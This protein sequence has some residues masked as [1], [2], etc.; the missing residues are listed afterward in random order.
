[1]G[2][3]GTNLEGF[4]AFE[5]GVNADKGAP[6]VSTNSDGA[7]ALL[8]GPA[9]L[10][11]IQA[12]VANGDFAIPPDAA[13]DTITEQNPLPYWTFTDVN[14]AGAITA[15][16]IVTAAAGSGNVLR[17]T[18]A[19]GTLTGKSAT[20]TR[21]VPVASSASRSFSYYTE[22]TFV[23]GTNSAQAEVTVSC[24]YY[25]Q[26]GVTTTGTAFSSTNI[27]FSDFSAPGQVDPLGVV[28]PDIF[29][30]AP[31]LTPATAPSDAAFIKLTIT[32]ATVAT[33]SAA[34]TLDLTEVRLGF[35]S[36]EIILTDKSIPADPPAV[37][38]C[39]NGSLYAIAPGEIALL[40]LG[41][42]TTLNAT[43]SIELTAPDI[44]LNGNNSLYAARI[45]TTAAQSL[46]N[47]TELKLTFNLASS[48]PSNESYDPQGWFN[49]ANDSIDI[50]IDGFYCITA[51]VALAA[52]A[53]GRRALIVAVNGATV[54]SVVFSASSSSGTNL[55]VTTN[56]YLFSGDQVT[57]FAFQN[58]GGALNT[59]SG[60]TALSVGRIG[61]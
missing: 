52:N 42:F 40:D 41:D 35:G 3:Y 6:L 12:G 17:F 49:N 4:G 8:F 51:N 19:S 31:D 45:R 7:T 2:K 50:G 22:A 32:I 46:T 33:Q 54:N 61:A 24:Q 57:S 9:A 48:T 5:G 44:V 43:T 47:N 53:T 10:R 30:A 23:N 25:K 56:I 39:T 58:S 27:P 26:D 38:Y 18:V 16:L 13:G 37:V 11:E 14:S 20:L 60:F 29:G 55:V 28:V 15:A 34:R 21:Y 59:V 1:M 36:P